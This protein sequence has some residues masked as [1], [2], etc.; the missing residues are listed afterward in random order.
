LQL[1]HDL[2]PRDPVRSSAT[3]ARSDV[4]VLSSDSSFALGVYPFTPVD[5]AS[6][7]VSS[8][9]NWFTRDSRARLVVSWRRIGFTSSR[10]QVEGLSVRRR[11]TNPA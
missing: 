1:G 3:S 10:P 7:D 8:S 4:R 2:E 6:A 11:T 9:V 5:A